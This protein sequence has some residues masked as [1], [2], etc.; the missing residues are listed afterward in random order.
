MPALPASAIAG[1]QLREGGRRPMFD[2]AF[3]TVVFASF[4]EKRQLRVPVDWRS[5]SGALDLVTLS[6][7][8]WQ[9]FFLISA[10][11]GLY[12]L[13]RLSPVPEEGEVPRREM[14]PQV[15]NVAQRGVRNA[16]TV[17]GCVPPSRS[18]PVG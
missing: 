4:F 18:R 13:R 9:F 10:V 12:S 15:L 5:P 7:G 11:V 17:A 16:S 14:L 8:G 6:V 3:A 2:A 1:P